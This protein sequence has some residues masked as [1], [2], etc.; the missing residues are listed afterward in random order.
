MIVTIHQPE[1]M[2]YL[3][4]FHKM[5][6]ADK[7]VLLDTVQFKKNNF[8]NRN[9]INISGNPSWLSLP[10]EKAA[11]STKIKDIKINNKV[12][13]PAKQLKT[14]SQ[15]Y[16]KHPYF[17][18]LFPMIEQ[19]YFKKHEYLSAFNSEFIL[20]MRDLLEI[21]TEILLASKLGLSGKA[22][23]GTEV[24]FEISKLL[25]AS[26]YI[27]GSG[28]KSYMNTELFEKNGIRVYF[29]EYKHPEYPQKNTVNFI[30]YL[31]IIDLFFNCGTNSL[32]FL[33]QNNL[34]QNPD[35]D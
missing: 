3:G 4:F 11:L 35:N 34:N 30:K 21:R 13:F 9:R 17:A 18:E 31:S 27:S 15:N 29:Q 14:I 33:M 28:G 12:F 22:T 19:L 32:N 6:M 1:F 23:G 20:G 10:I 24:T 26:V 25:N 8:Q 7:L 16:S 2:P 5:A